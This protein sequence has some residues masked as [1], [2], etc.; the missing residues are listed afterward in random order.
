MTQDP[1]LNQDGPPPPG[2]RRMRM[3]ARLVLWF[4]T[5]WPAVA[6]A[7]GVSLLVVCVA[8]LDL[9]RLLP[10]A[11]HI[12]FLAMSGL[13]VL[14]ALGLGL[15]KIRRPGLSDADRRLEADSGLRHQPL[16]VLADRP[17][18]SADAPAIALWSA[19]VARAKAQIARLRLKAPRPMLAA[20]DPRALRAFVLIAFAACLGIAGPDSWTRVMGALHPAFSKALP[21]PAAVLQAWI[22]P[23]GYTGLPPIFLKSDGAEVSAPEGSKLSVSVTGGAAGEPPV[24]ELA[25]TQTP[26]PPLDAT[27]FQVERDLTD[28][29]RI[30]VRRQGRALGAWDLA[31]VPNQ[32]PVVIFPEPP[33]LLR[34]PNPQ[35]RLPW[36]VTHA[37]G[38]VSLQAEIRLTARPEA[39]P[40]VLNIPLPG[41]APKTA[42]GN[43]VVD[44]TAH[45]WAG[46][47][48]SGQ[49][50]ARD[51][52]GLVGRSA[53]VPFT[54]PERR[55]M[56]AYARTVIYIRR[57]LSLTPDDRQSAIRELD[58]LSSQREAWDGDLSGFV[59]LRAIASLLY[60][61]RAPETVAQ[62]QDRMWSLA[63]HLEEGAADRT[64][65]SLEAAR[66]QLRDQMEAEKKAE[67]RARDQEKADAKPGDKA[68]DKATADK[69]NP[70]DK[71][72]QPKQA[73]KTDRD[74][75]I[76]AEIDKKIRALQDALQKR[77]DALSDQARR[78]PNAEGYNPDA[79]PMD[80]R[81]MQRLTEEMRE[82]NKKDDTE[83]ARDKLA[84]LEKMMEALKDGRPERG[85][86]TERERQRAEKRQQGQQQMTALQDI[87]KREGNILDSAQ[88]RA[89]AS[90]PLRQPPEADPRRAEQRT[91]LA[92]R[93]A[94]GELMQQYGDLTG[95]VP[96][97]LG[98][99]DT[100]M[101]DGAQALGQ[102]RDAQAA[103][104]AQ[105]AIEAL[106]KGGKSMQQQMARQF[107]RGDQQGDEGEDGDEG[108]GEGMAQGD[109][110]GQGDGPG[111]G[112]GRQF[113]NRQGDTPGFNP[114]R[115]NPGRQQARRPSLNLDPLGRPRGEGTGGTDEAGDVQVPEEMEA[116]R[117]RALQEELRR[118]GA[119]RTRPQDELDYIERLLKQF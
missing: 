71:A 62:A 20:V 27:S 64:A 86:M 7:I 103:Q 11:F 25:G 79:H 55:F 23:P 78:D 37:Y 112:Q 106:Q 95:E 15:R 93:R 48:V 99:A 53:S 91:Q 114:G 22:T 8:L 58:R 57:Q 14:V 43:R 83:A 44:L 41:S 32:A 36:Q 2:L 65:K 68:D 90:D 34:G 105:R 50:V 109:G 28:S 73:E 116:A 5:I 76:R 88:S 24:L 33:G 40:M 38:V 92:L 107:G 104:S 67:E 111:S 101:R 35:T 118:R 59:N 46:L 42:R 30:T 18:V 98:E 52:P 9:P 39:A 77:L 61:G 87:I 108:E 45:P 21:P 82:S 75:A 110:D 4:E 10:P 1:A 70:S 69:A 19:H 54:L 60:R 6:P 97:N 96:P 51:A 26:F 3:L 31:V 12:A 17:S 63:L 89:S 72:D 100:A 113:G 102:A 119:D 49:L 66:Q 74:A 117:T 13:A 85:K 81:D 84:E 80:Q 16:A 56:N 47:E 94:V 115:P 29:G